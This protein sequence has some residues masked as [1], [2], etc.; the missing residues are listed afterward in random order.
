MQ[1]KN[2]N[3][4]TSASNKN[5]KNAAAAAM[6]ANGPVVNG[7]MLNGAHRMNGGG[8]GGGGEGGS[9]PTSSPYQPLPPTSSTYLHMASPYLPVTS[10]KAS[11][12]Q[13]LPV[14][15]SSYQPM[16][17]QQ[18]LPRPPRRQDPP[19]ATHEGNMNL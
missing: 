12:Y 2:V 5:E 15:S 9:I 10:S 4:Q 8:A 3:V 14:T 19:L 16:N 6:T 13:H 18:A 11:P 1:T 17:G 7:G